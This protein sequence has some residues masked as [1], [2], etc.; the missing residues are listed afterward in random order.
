LTVWQVVAAVAQAFTLQNP[1]AVL[2]MRAD[3]GVEL[4]KACAQINE[5]RNR[6]FKSAS[7]GGGRTGSGY[8]DNHDGTRTYSFGSL[9]ELGKRMGMM[10]S[11]EPAVKKNTDGTTTIHTDSMDMLRSTLSRGPKKA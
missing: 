8:T 9:A 7:G 1:L 4:M 10:N 11:R 3:V 2:L 5:I 6:A